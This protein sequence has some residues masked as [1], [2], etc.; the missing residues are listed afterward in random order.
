[1][2][3]VEQE[4]ELGAWGQNELLYEDAL[5]GVC[6]IMQTMLHNNECLSQWENRYLCFINLL[7]W[8]ELAVHF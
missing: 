7:T 2:S 4:H 8:Q 1:M 5:R 3:F 6:K